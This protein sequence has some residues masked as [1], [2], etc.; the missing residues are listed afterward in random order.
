[1][2]GR[3]GHEPFGACLPVANVDAVDN[4]PEAFAH[5]ADLA[6]D[7]GAAGCDGAAD[8]GSARVH[9]PLWLSRPAAGDV[10]GVS[11]S[12][13]RASCIGGDPRE[14]VDARVLDEVAGDGD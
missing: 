13:E 12:S 10:P 2:R 7:Q 3:V 11:E 5:G 9:D 8:A 14:E 6:V 4:V 1:M